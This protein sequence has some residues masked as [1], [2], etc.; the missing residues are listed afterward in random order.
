MG[1]QASHADANNSRD[2]IG[3][4]EGG[5]IRKIDSKASVVLWR[6][7]KAAGA[8]LTN[9]VCNVQLVGIIRARLAASCCF[10][11]DAAGC[12]ET[13]RKNMFTQRKSNTDMKQQ[14]FVCQPACPRVHLIG[15][16]AVWALEAVVRRSRGSHVIS[17]GALGTNVYVRVLAGNKRQ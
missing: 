16:C 9:T 4:N 17:H 13:A 10:V 6:C 5:R 14:N 2:Y 7:E 8:G 11:R 3:E 12:A 15:K 1:R